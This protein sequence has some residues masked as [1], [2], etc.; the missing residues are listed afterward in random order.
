MFLLISVILFLILI[1]FLVPS[2]EKH[3]IRNKNNKLPVGNLVPTGNLYRDS[4]GQKWVKRPYLFSLLH[5]PNKN[6]IF[7]TYDTTIISSSEAIAERKLFDSGTQIFTAGTFN[8]YS[9]FQNPLMHLFSDILP[10]IIY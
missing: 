10:I 6:Y 7:E 2:R 5:N 3:K 4:V 1:Y 8:Y 9:P